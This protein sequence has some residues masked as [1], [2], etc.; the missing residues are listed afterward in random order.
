[1][2]QQLLPRKDEKGRVPALDILVA[3]ARA[4]ECLRDPAKLPGL[5]DVMASGSDV[6]MRTFE[7]HLV[8]LVKAGTVAAETALAASLVP[9]PADDAVAPTARPSKR[10]KGG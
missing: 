5:R 2:S 3:T 9:S 6:G 7:Q 8:E 4:R 10:G 1:V